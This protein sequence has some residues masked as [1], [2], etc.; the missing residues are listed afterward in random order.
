[1]R[2]GLGD[3]RTAPV[4]PGPSGMNVLRYWAQMLWDPLA[5]YGVLRRTYGD[6]VRVPLSRNRSFFLLDRPEYAEHVLLKHQDQYVR[7][8]IAR[9]LKAF[10]GDGLL[11][12]EGAVWQR[13][14]RLVQPVFSHRH[15]QSFAP[16][17][18]DAARKRFAQWVPG[19][20]IDI[21]VEMRALT[22]DVIGRALFGMDLSSDAAMVGRAETR[23]QSSMA[24]RAAAIHLAFLSPERIRAVATRIAPALGEASQT[25]N[26]LVAR[27]IDAR[28]RA[29]HDEPSDLLDL[30][31]AAG[32]DEQPLSRAEIQ[33][34][35]M[36]L[37]L[38]GH[39]T[40]THALTFTL[41]LLSRNPAAYERMIAEVDDVLAGR[42]P[43]ATDVDSL[44]WTQAV[45]NEALRLY[46][47]GCYIIRDAAEDDH[48][49][50][51]QV[52]AGDTIALSPYLLH[53]IPEF[54]P[55]P[56]RFDPRRFLPNSA[57]TYPRYAY[58]PFGAGR[59]I[60]LGA[61]LAFLEMTLVLAVFA[62]S[63]VVDAVQ[64][65]PLRVRGDVTL[66]PVQ[67]VVVTVAPAHSR[68]HTTR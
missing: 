51:V 65:G 43:Q 58:L 18:V 6:T 10:L 38:T 49:S 67:P 32:Q 62:Q 30:L 68:Q 29:P 50:G 42:D 25:L 28:I 15:M 8:F 46:P 34:E 59:R 17:I 24:L 5:T 21:A 47:P 26:S 11:T 12:A 48:I 64:T 40:T 9:P 20:R 41:A 39:E 66:H 60:C 44:P 13:H 53:R 33:D 16:T 19:T 27:I 23:L 61:S 3:I 14:R 22:M 56:E 52:F 7:T 57:S 2:R 54:W 36:T 63:V 1:M 55:D 37:V 31:L 4:P 35:V 45:V